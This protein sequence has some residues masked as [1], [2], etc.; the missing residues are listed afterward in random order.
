M[1]SSSCKRRRAG[2][3]PIPIAANETI[4]SGPQGAF[5]ATNLDQELTVPAGQFELVAQRR[6]QGEHLLGFFG[7]LHGNQDVGLEP[8]DAQ[9]ARAIHAT[10]GALDRS[11]GEIESTEREVH[12]GEPNSRL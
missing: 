9:L 2:P 7:L 11:P 3:P 12:F 4:S 8:C 10:L 1:R 6:G 5:A